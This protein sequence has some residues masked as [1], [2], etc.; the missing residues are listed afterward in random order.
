LLSGMSGRN[1][2]SNPSFSL[3]DHWVAKTNDID[4]FSF[5]HV[6]SELRSKSRIF[7][8]NWSY[9]AVFMAQNLET[10]CYHRSSE[11]LSVFSK[12]GN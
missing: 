1:L 12:I 3:G 11:I 10:S 9:G 8:E 5:H 2:N 6:I 7:Q 4:V